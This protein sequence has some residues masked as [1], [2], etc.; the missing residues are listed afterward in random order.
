LGLA[1]LGH[2]SVFLASLED[3]KVWDLKGS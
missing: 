1:F 3:F 2:C